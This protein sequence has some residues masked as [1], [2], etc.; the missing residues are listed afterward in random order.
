M[1]IKKNFKMAGQNKAENDQYGSLA[2]SL[3]KYG[4][5]TGPKFSNP[6]FQNSNFGI[7]QLL[8]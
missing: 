8:L 1:Q 4:I 2:G 7:Y 6:N 3:L 5:P